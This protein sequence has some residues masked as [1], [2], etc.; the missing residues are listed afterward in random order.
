MAYNPAYYIIDPK[1][2]TQSL[3]EYLNNSMALGTQVHLE[4]PLDLIN[5]KITNISHKHLLNMLTSGCYQVDNIDEQQAECGGSRQDKQQM[6]YLVNSDLIR[7]IESSTS[8]FAR[9]RKVLDPLTAANTT[10]KPKKSRCA[11]FNFS[12]KYLYSLYVFVKFLYLLSALC[13]LVFLNRLIGNNFYVLGFTL[14][15]TFFME[16]EWPHLDVFPVFEL[17]LLFPIF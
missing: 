8:S 4:S 17:F 12:D 15:K 9:Q 3:M 5:S 1:V 7:H 13:Q 10:K 16:I 11:L 2:D 6:A 14:I